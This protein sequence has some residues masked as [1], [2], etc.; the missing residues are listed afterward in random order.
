MK[1]SRKTEST[2]AGCVRRLVSRRREQL[3]LEAL[4][5]LA[6]R[7]DTE[8]VTAAEIERYTRRP[9]RLTRADQAA[10]DRAHPKLLA[11]LKREL[12]PVAK[13]LE[14]GWGKPANDRVK[15]HPTN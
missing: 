9:V 12:R 10:L 11:A 1:P 14:S 15:Q 8:E 7:N 3:A 13:R 5:A 4:V 6:L 2:N